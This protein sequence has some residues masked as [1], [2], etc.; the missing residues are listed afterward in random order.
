MW[1]QFILLSRSRSK[2]R[3]SPR[4]L[5]TGTGSTGSHNLISATSVS[6]PLKTVSYI[7]ITRVRRPS[8]QAVNQ[9]SANVEVKKKNKG[10]RRAARVITAASEQAPMEDGGRCVLMHC[11]GTRNVTVL[12]PVSLRSWKDKTLPHSHIVMTCP[13][14]AVACVLI[15]YLDVAL[16]HRCATLRLCTSA[17]CR[18]FNYASVAGLY[19]FQWVSSFAANLIHARETIIPNISRLGYR[20]LSQQM[21][22]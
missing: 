10:R 22:F 11:P 17:P 19:A 5:W 8:T 4:E 13:G 16:S 18:E 9:L 12:F 14:T 3:R 20:P 7:T 2:R 1:A 6:G 21:K 15:L